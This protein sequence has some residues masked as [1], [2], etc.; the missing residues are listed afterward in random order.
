MCVQGVGTGAYLTATLAILVNKFPDKK[1]AVKACC[2]GS[3]QFGLAIG[4][5][6]GAFMYSAAG[7]FFPFAVCGGAIILSGILVLLLTEVG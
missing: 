5:V 4:P 2:E 1:A 7:F 6:L 3:F